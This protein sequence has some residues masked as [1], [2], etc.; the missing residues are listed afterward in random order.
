M[1]ASTAS[2]QTE[3]QVSADQSQHDP[4]GKRERPTGIDGLIAKGLADQDEAADEEAKRGELGPALGTTRELGGG[5]RDAEPSHEDYPRPDS[6][7]HKRDRERDPQEAPI[8][9]EPAH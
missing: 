6:E 5:K 4:A 3:Q 1:T 8:R 9:Q 2:P 7:D